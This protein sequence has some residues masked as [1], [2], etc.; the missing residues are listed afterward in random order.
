M[1]PL[2]QGNPWITPDI[3]ALQGSLLTGCYPPSATR[4]YHFGGKNTWEHLQ[5]L[6]E[7]CSVLALYLI[8]KT[9]QTSSL[10]MD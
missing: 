4:K 9:L 2:L 10:L 6:W 8:T 1:A 7:R 3:P 5:L